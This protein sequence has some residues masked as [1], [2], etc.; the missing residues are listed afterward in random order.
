MQNSSSLS[1]T[2]REKRDE[3]REGESNPPETCWDTPSLRY[4]PREGCGTQS[5]LLICLENAA[6]LSGLPTFW[7]LQV[8]ESHLIYPRSP[9]LSFHGSLTPD[10][11][12]CTFLPSTAGTTTSLFYSVHG[13]GSLSPA[14]D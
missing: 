11:A 4:C 14:W 10:D 7:I 8:S 6:G 1:E 3:P 5:L 9:A 12:A 13:S 2:E